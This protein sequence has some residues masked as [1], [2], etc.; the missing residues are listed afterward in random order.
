M[1]ALNIVTIGTASVLTQGPNEGT[2]IEADF[3]LYRAMA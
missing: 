3:V 1:K 2:L